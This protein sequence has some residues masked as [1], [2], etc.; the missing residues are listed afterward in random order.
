MHRTWARH[1]KRA[2]M[3]AVHRRSISSTAGDAACRLGCGL[4]TRSS[5]A[6]T[7]IDR[8]CTYSH[9][10]TACLRPG[11]PQQCMR[12]RSIL[13]IH[14]PPCRD[15]SSGA[16]RPGNTPGSL[17][18]KRIAPFCIPRHCGECLCLFARLHQTCTLSLSADT[19]ACHAAHAAWWHERAHLVQPPQRARCLQHHI[20]AAAFVSAMTAVPAGRLI[21]V[22]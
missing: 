11:A 5:R 15:T 8:T 10:C 7:A 17:R 14:T 19:A 12:H 4:S 6:A 3:W 1:G 13:S 9:Q 16:S 20:H 21:Q 18:R 2:Q 22:L